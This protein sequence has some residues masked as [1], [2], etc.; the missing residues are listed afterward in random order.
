MFS[1]TVLNFWQLSP[2]LVDEISNFD[3]S[4]D[5][6]V[7]CMHTPVRALVMLFWPASISFILYFGNQPNFSHKCEHVVE[8]LLSCDHVVPFSYVNWVRSLPSVIQ[9]RA[10]SIGFVAALGSWISQAIA[11]KNW[12]YCIGACN[13]FNKYYTSLRRLYDE[14]WVPRYVW[15]QGAIVILWWLYPE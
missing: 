3:H 9:L 10:L 7:H 2:T 11:T 6:S 8:I 4:S 5:A 14:N 1:Y 12:Q 15:K 13:F